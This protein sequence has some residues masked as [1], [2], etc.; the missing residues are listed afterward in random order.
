MTVR[1]RLALIPPLVEA[2]EERVHIK[3]TDMSFDADSKRIVLMEMGN[4]LT[5]LL[6]DLRNAR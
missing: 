5:K 1:G 2:L 3:L 4:H 6:K